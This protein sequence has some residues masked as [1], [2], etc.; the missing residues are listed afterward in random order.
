MRPF[1]LLSVLS[2]MV[3]AGLP[4][5]AAAQ[6][7]THVD[8]APLPVY[9]ETGD[10]WDV[11][12][13]TADGG[14]WVARPGDPASPQLS[15]WTTDPGEARDAREAMTK[16]ADQYGLEDVALLPVA[17]VPSHVQLLGNPLHVG[18][19][20]ARFG[21][22]DQVIAMTARQAGTDGVFT[23]QILQA[24]P[25]DFASWDGVLGPLVTFQ[26]L[27]DGSI[28]DYALRSQVRQAP[29]REQLEIYSRIAET[30]AAMTAQKAAI[31]R[32]QVQMNTLDLMRQMNDNMT[33]ETSC[34]LIAGCQIGYDGQGNAVMTDN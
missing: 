9:T 20:T 16:V 7:R 28:F 13:W 5:D 34:I 4:T 14:F 3:L 18:L 11:P 1:T 10:G 30:F 19:A 17:L 2:L 8:T 15:L 26:F 22:R 6:S 27:E 23:V 29:L 25:E 24:P 12:G 31:M 32:G 21:G 33:T